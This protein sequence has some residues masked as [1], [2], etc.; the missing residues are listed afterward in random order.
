MT[1]NLDGFFS[2]LI[3]LAV[4]R[5]QIYC[6]A[7]INYSQQHAIQMRK[8]GVIIHTKL[9]VSSKSAQDDIVPA[10]PF[11]RNDSRIPTTLLTQPATSTTRP[12][13]QTVQQVCSAADSMYPFCGHLAWQRRRIGAGSAAQM[14]RRVVCGVSAAHQSRL[15]MLCRCRER[16]LH[17][18]SVAAA[19]EP[20]LA[21]STIAGDACC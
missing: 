12:G 1:S 16:R 10:C 17:R 6:S 7:K 8:G 2:V 14:I 9:P 5:V 18:V 13:L 21:S 11:R 19:V 3:A 4:Q 15:L 20:R